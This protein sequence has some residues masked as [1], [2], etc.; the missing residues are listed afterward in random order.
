MLWDWKGDG[1]CLGVV[2]FVDLFTSPCCNE[3]VSI[4]PKSPKD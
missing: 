4:G 2:D 1:L 3:G